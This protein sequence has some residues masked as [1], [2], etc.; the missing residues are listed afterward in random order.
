MK[1]LQIA[2]LNGKTGTLTEPKRA[3]LPVTLPSLNVWPKWHWALKKKHQATLYYL[4]IQAWG[5][6]PNDWPQAKRFLHVI[7][8]RPGTLDQDNLEGSVKPLIDV[9]KRWIVPPSPKRKKNPYGVPG[10]GWIW[11]DCPAWFGYK[12]DQIRTKRANVGTVLL[13]Q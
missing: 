7:E 8:Y 2:Y 12:V 5:V 6:A 4:I 11:D 9:L 1:D 3:F 10:A 13:L